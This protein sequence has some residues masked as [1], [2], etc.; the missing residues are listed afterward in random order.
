MAVGG[1]KAVVKEII[2]AESNW[3]GDVIVSLAGFYRKISVAGET[4]ALMVIMAKIVDEAFPPNHT[5]KGFA[6]GSSVMGSDAFMSAEVL[7]QGEVERFMA[8]CVA[9]Q[10]CGNMVVAKG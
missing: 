7:A 5:V 4:V 1:V 10:E 9:F 6:Y 8:L 3:L 2:H